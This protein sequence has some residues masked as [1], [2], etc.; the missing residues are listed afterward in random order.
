MGDSTRSICSTLTRRPLPMFALA[1]Q[2]LGARSRD[3]G[4]TRNAVTG[5]PG[6]GAALTLRAPSVS[7]LDSQ[8]PVEVPPSPVAAPVAAAVDPPPVKQEQF[9]FLSVA[10]FSEEELAPGVFNVEFFVVW[11]SKD[12]N[13]HAVGTWEPADALTPAVRT[14][15]LLRL[16]GGSKNKRRWISYEN[17]YRWMEGQL[18][19]LASAQQPRKAPS[20][21]TVSASG[22]SRQRKRKSAGSRASSRSSPSTRRRSSSPSLSSDI[23]ESSE[24]RMPLSLLR[25]RASEAGPANAYQHL[26]A[27]EAAARSRLS[28]KM[29]ALTD[30]GQKDGCCRNWNNNKACFCP[31]GGDSQ[32]KHECHFRVC[33][34]PT[35][36]HMGAFCR[37]RPYSVEGGAPSRRHAS[38]AEAQSSAAAAAPSGL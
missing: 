26:M 11:D 37:S 32:R 23:S 2:R 21:S 17:G 30:N 28:P 27:S 9:A 18:V 31:P 14:R 34:D 6:I 3:A 19:Q 10:L 8:P 1:G 4:A 33:T 29:A 7:L 22:R 13:G 12:E 5:S 24:D 38:L 35:P 15:E 20:N 36:G 25:D 16:T